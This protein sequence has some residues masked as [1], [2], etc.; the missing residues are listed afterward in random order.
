M[1]AIKSKTRFN[2]FSILAKNLVWH[3]VWNV[4]GVAPLS[5]TLKA[6]AKP[7]KAASIDASANSIRLAC[8]LRLHRQR[9]S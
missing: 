1:A 3:R 8:R 4:A 5:K 9:G 7:R 6:F 2:Q